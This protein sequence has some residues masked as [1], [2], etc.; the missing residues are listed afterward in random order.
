MRGSP[1]AVYRRLGVGNI[2]V[3]SPRRGRMRVQHIRPLFS[4]WKPHDFE[5][6]RSPETFLKGWWYGCCVSLWYY[7][8]LLAYLFF[9][10]PFFSLSHHT[11]HYHRHQ[12]CLITI[13]VTSFAPLISFSP[14][15]SFFPLTSFSPVTSFCSNISFSPYSLLLQAWVISGDYTWHLFLPYYSCLLSY[16]LVRLP[17]LFFWFSFLS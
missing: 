2:R 5:Q 11:H 4:G 17:F 12:S 8:F 14:L 16:L 1:R 6:A 15:V 3:L 10:S 7:L 9:L 13:H